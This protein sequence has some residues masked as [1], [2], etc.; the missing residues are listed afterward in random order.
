MHWQKVEAKEFKIIEN[1]D[2]NYREP[3]DKRYEAIDYTV[4]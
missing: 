1:T 4:K 2:H 3:E